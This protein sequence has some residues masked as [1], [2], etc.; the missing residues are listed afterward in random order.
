MLSIMRQSTSDDTPKSAMGTSD[1]TG[2][3]YQTRDMFLF[4]AIDPTVESNAD[5]N[6]LTK[7][8]MITPTDK[9]PW[10]EKKQTL[11]DIFTKENCRSVRSMTW[12]ALPKIIELSEPIAESI[13]NRTSKDHRFAISEAILMAAYLVIWRGNVNP[14][15]KQIDKFVSDNYKE[16]IRK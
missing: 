4:L 12:E 6:R 14:T 8:N 9:V 10:N 3:T 13:Q 11:I 2:T 5:D 7:I 15:T 1:Q 16:K